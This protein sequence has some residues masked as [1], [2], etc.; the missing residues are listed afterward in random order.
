MIDVHV[1]LREPGFERKETIE[2]GSKA[3]VRGGF[4][5]VA[6]MPNTNPVID[7]PDLVE[8]IA[9]KSRQY[10]FAKVLPIG[11][12]TIGQKGQELADLEGMQK[13]GAI[14]FSD[15]GKGVASTTMMQQAM[16]RAKEINAP[17]LA[18]CED[19]ELAKG[20]VIH[21]G[22]TSQQLGVP[23]IPAESEFLQLERD[24]ILA[25]LT[26]VHYHLCHISSHRSVDLVRQ[27]KARGVKV[28]AE[29][30]PHHLTLMEEDVKEPYS[31]YKMNP[32]LRTEADKQALIEGFMDGTIDMIATDHAPHTEDEKG[33]GLL[34]SPFGIVG[35][36]TAF[37]VLYTQLV[38]TGMITLERLLDSLTVQPATLLKIE[39]GEIEIGKTA[40]LTIID[41]ETKKKVNPNTF[42]SKG[43]NTPFTGLEL[44]GWPVLTIVDGKIVWEQREEE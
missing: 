24:L 6:A 21:E 10:G 32:P 9:M 15:D 38:K 2:T 41:L 3:A 1:H 36:E 12:I 20:G 7:Q 19:T 5:T 14:G 39:S 11:A 44:Q 25:E 37:P 22:K 23:G 16:E 43:K 30:T 27:A 42:A 33:K 4:T 13:Q 8:Y 34:G 31:Q 35:L 26:G 18:H 40:D 29:V 17:I 28:T